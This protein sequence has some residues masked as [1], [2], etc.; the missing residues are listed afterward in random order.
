[1]AFKNDSIKTRKRSCNE[2]CMFVN[3]LFHGVLRSSLS[4]VCLLTE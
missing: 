2:L 3:E 4:A 1:M